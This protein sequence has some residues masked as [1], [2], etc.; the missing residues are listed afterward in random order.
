M[1]ARMSASHTSTWSTASVVCL[2]LSVMPLH[3]QTPTAGQGLENK[4]NCNS[5][6]VAEATN[7]AESHAAA[8]TSP[9]NMGS[10]GWTGGTGGA[11]MGT[12]PHGAVPESKTW[13]PPTVRGLDL[14]MPIPATAPDAKAGAC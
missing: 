2:S 6:S 7:A 8:G 11:H 13:Q 12:S 4:A 1:S 14:A 10:T 9:G 5:A 3:A